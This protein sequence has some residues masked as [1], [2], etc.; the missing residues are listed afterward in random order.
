[1]TLS[2]VAPLCYDYR[3]EE[4]KIRHVGGISRPYYP[5]HLGSKSHGRRRVEGWNPQGGKHADGKRIFG[6]QTRR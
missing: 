1:M 3:Y 2:Q 6:Q 5:R 4:A